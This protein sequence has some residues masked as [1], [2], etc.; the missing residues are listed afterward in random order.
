[1]EK[2]LLFLLNVTPFAEASDVSGHISVS[3]FFSQDDPSR[4]GSDS[5]HAKG[6]D[7]VI[8][9]GHRCSETKGNM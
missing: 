7:G 4:F 1:M 6:H 2:L 9:I 5:F 3:Q 8:Q